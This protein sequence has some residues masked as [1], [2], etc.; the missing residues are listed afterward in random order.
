LRSWQS[1]SLLRHFL[2]FMEPDGSHNPAKGPYSDASESR[3]HSHIIPLSSTCKSC[4]LPGPAPFLEAI[5]LK[6]SIS[7]LP[8]CVPH[9]LCSPLD[10]VC[11]TVW[12]T[13]CPSAS[14]YFIAKNTRND[15]SSSVSAKKVWVV[16]AALRYWTFLVF[17][18]RDYYELMK[19]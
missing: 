9:S 19:S 12:T 4:L 5:G 3:P 16:L 1:L 2:P 13:Y 14:R 10:S 8:A 15:L 7:H 6:S 17:P 18:K 11:G